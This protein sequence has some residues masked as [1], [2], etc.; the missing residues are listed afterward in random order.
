MGRMLQSVLCC[1][2]VMV[3][4]LMIPRPGSAVNIVVNPG[5]E[6]V[7]TPGTFSPWV[8]NTNQWGVKSAATASGFIAPNS[9]TYFA[10][11]GCNASGGNNCLSHFP[12]PAGAWLYQELPT[13]PG[14]LYDFSFYYAPGAGTSRVELQAYWNGT[15]VQDILN[16]DTRAYTQYTSTGLLANAT[17]TTRIE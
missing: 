2:A 11:T 3:V 7:G 15:L 12:D 9:G 16:G 13:V 10:Q 1:V 4:G 8:A 6:G 17:G 14:T 5:F